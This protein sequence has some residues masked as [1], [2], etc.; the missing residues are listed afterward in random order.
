MKS[1]GKLRNNGGFV[2]SIRIQ[3]T[4]LPV[5]MR[6]QVLEGKIDTKFDGFFEG[7]CEGFRIDFGSQNAAKIAPKVG[8]LET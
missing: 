2:E 4:A 1:D 7:F 5:S 8:L 6:S 3:K